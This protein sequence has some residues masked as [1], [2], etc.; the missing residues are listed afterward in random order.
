VTRSIL[1]GTTLSA[2]DHPKI[3]A[4]NVAGMLSYTNSLD[5]I[6]PNGKAMHVGH[7]RFRRKNPAE[8]VI[9]KISSYCENART[10]KDTVPL[11]PLERP[12]EAAPQQ[13]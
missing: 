10:T 11:P 5:V 12:A 3:G 2:R 4:V 9:V 1:N 13:G 7:V 6:H 8:N